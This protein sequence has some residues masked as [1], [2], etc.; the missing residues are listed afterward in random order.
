MDE[1]VVPVVEMPDPEMVVMT[2]V[3]ED[4][5]EPRI[6]LDGCHPQIAVA[7]FR[8]AADM[9]EAITT[10]PTITTHGDC[11]RQKK[12]TCSTLKQMTTNSL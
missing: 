8:Q 10:R 6:E 3:L 7:V 2:V 11:S 12:I 5:S 1:E 4:G 9:L